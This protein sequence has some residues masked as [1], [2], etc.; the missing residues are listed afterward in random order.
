VNDVANPDA[1]AAVLG[2]CIINPVA[3]SAVADHL[4]PPDFW[5]SANATIYET[6][7]DFYHRGQPADLVMLSDALQGQTFGHEKMPAA[8]YLAGL[9]SVTPSS[10]NIVRYA[11]IVLK[12]A[13]TRLLR[14]LGTG[15]GAVTPQSLDEHLTKLHDALTSIERRATGR[16]WPSLEELVN[17]NEK[18]LLGLIADDARIATGVVA[19]DGFK[20]V[21]KR[22]K[23]TV[24]AARTSVGKTSLSATIAHHLAYAGM[25]VGFFSAEM[26]PQDILNKLLAIE[27]RMDFQHLTEG[28]KTPEEQRRIREAD[29]HLKTLSLDIVPA[30]G[31]TVTQ[32]AKA[33]RAMAAKRPLDLIIVDYLQI[34]DNEKKSD[35][36]YLD[37]GSNSIALRNVGKAEN[38]AMLV[39]SQ[40]RRP[41]PG[42]MGKPAPITLP[43]LSDL[44]ESGSIEQDSDAV[45]F[46]S[47]PESVEMKDW[48]QLVVKPVVV[49]VAKNRL[50]AKGIVTL[51]FHGPRMEFLGYR[52]D[53]RFRSDTAASGKDK[54][55]GQDGVNF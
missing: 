5:I 8:A 12:H 31:W 19:L 54:A 13:R 4:T 28:V 48:E 18:V 40:L 16:T 29:A 38:C 17:E 24:L 51:D 53:A 41:T 34:L 7:L 37:V 52:A 32:V 22:R 35:A 6:M 14:D 21:L 55:A 44:R 33:A 46:L 42:F 30:N 39:L 47:P 20:T 26:D 36:R 43:Q 2:A 3:I 1:E 15:L 11:D 23:M 27:L 45:V 9:A 10:V 50:G 25:H 49:Y